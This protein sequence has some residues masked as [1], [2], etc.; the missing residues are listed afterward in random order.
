[1][2]YKFYTKPAQEAPQVLYCER[3]TNL[4]PGIR[5]GPVIRNV[6]IF[7][8][9]AAGYGS[10]IING[11]EFPVGPGD[12]YILMPGDTVIHTADKIEP[13]SG[14]C[15][16]AN[17]L[18]LGNHL[19]RAGISSAQPFAPKEIFQ[20][21]YD[22]IEQM[23]AMENENDM[24][25]ELHRTACLYHILGLLFKEC[26]NTDRDAVIQRA[27]GIMET[28]YSEQLS[29]Q[30]LADYIGLERSYF[31]TFFKN[32]TGMPP[33]RYL[34]RLRVQKACVLMDRDSIPIA[35]VAESVGLDAQNFA[36][37]FKREMGMTPL[38]YKQR[39]G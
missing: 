13:R 33:H 2:K 37:I 10:V 25:A 24:G 4:K 1:M 38:Q 5:Y 30:D 39:S 8:C 3:D 16:I 28:R 12:C 21:I 29:T 34:T 35:T 9:C 19:A 20:E 31:S 36:R 6:Y 26:Q 23:L 14:V 7:E 32:Q 18:S 15:C 27:I 11:K 17:G 22:L